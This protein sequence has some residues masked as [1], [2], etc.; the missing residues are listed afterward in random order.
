MF[1]SVRKPPRTRLTAGYVVRRAIDLFRAGAERAM[2]A[3]A[4][5]ARSGDTLRI[6][7]PEGYAVSGGVDV[8]FGSVDRTMGLQDF[9]DRYLKTCGAPQ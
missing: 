9:A 5:P 8:S 6:R 4:P 1:V 2:R 7:M 3:E